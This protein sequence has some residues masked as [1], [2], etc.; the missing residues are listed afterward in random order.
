MDI[1]T[2]LGVAFAAATVAAMN[3]A[4]DATLIEEGKQIR[5]GLEALIRGAILL[6][7]AGFHFDLFVLSC[8]IFWIVFEIM[9]NLLRR[10][11][12]LYVG[13]TAWQDRMLRKWFPK[14]P[15]YIL[16]AI[17]LISLIMAV[18]YV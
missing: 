4:L 6:A 14:H 17:K 2:T 3:A 12:L 1:M 7:L 11:P 10:K 8:A 13:Y 15:E 16:L 5:H 18:A 9:L